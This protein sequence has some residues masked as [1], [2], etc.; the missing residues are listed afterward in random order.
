MEALYTAI[1]VF[2]VSLA[3]PETQVVSLARV[4]AAFPMNLLISTSKDRLSLIMDPRH[5]N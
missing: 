3:F 1:L 2:T 4:D 5:V